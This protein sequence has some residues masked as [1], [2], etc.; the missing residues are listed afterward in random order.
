MAP[1]W[2]SSEMTALLRAWAD[3]VEMPTTLSQT[4]HAP[5]TLFQHFVALCGGQTQRTEVSVL[6]RRDILKHMW[7]LI[8]KFESEQQQPQQSWFALPE[9]EKRVVFAKSQVKSYSLLDISRATYLEV[10]QI[11]ASRRRQIEREQKRA[12]LASQQAV[13]SEDPHCQTN[14]I[15]E[16][17]NSSDDEAAD[18]SAAVNKEHEAIGESFSRQEDA[19]AEDSG[20]STES[21]DDFI[22]VDEPSTPPQRS[23]VRE[24]RQ[25]PREQQPIRTSPL[26]RSR[27]AFEPR[28]AACRPSDNGWRPILTHKN[29]RSKPTETSSSVAGPVMPWS[30][31]KLKVPETASSSK[32]A[33]SA[34]RE[35]VEVRCMD[36]LN[37][38]L[39][40]ERVVRTPSRKPVAKFVPTSLREALNMSPRPLEAPASNNTEDRA[41]GAAASVPT[42]ARKLMCSDKPAH[43]GDRE[44]AE[45]R[46]MNDLNVWLA[47]ERLAKSPSHKPTVTYT[48]PSLC[49]APKPSVCSSA[50]TAIARYGA[51]EHATEPEADIKISLSGGKLELV[52]P[53]STSDRSTSDEVADRLNAQA[54]QLRAVFAAFRKMSESDVALTN[55]FLE[56]VQ[57]DMVD[58]ERVQ[59][60][61][62]Q[63]EASIGREHHE[64][65][66]ERARLRRDWD[67]LQLRL[68]RSQD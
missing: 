50:P 18:D 45:V 6:A 22:I 41:S 24:E 2:S 44:V 21:D 59:E 8:T 1:Q 62:R 38:W 12:L 39:E 36:D 63:L 65:A 66:V 16:K 52:P 4:R 27:E 42:E 34:E 10:E 54:N 9:W 33:P 26:S 57:R 25:P 23:P 64:W 43:N 48:L 32:A 20:S 14:A 49:E 68:E 17:V 56:E 37:T 35:V 5:S 29:K 55:Q 46:Y 3:V 60:Q 58:R 11:M 61:V 51:F 40:K 53:P 30:G 31:Q 67:E 15:V 28:T 19:P 7:T 47:K 13:I